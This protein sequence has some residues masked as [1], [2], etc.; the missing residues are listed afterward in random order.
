[1]IDRVMSPNSWSARDVGREAFPA[2]SGRR[3]IPFGFAI[4]LVLA[5]CGAR[6]SL[7]EGER[8]AAQDAGP[9]APLDAVTDTTW[10]DGTLPDVI[11]DA[12]VVTSCADLPPVLNEACAVPGH[13]CAYALGKQGPCDDV[14]TADRV[15]WRCEPSGWLEI[16]RCVE[17]GAC[18]PTPPADGDACDESVLGLDCYY[19]SDE[20]CERGSIAQCDG[21]R[22]WHVNACP[23]RDVPDGF[24][25]VSS[26]TEPDLTAVAH[27]EQQV[28]QPSLAVAGTQLLMAYY[29]SAGYLQDHGIHGHV[30]QTSAPVQTAPYYTTSTDLLGH[31]AVSNPRVTYAEGRFILSWG[32]N[33]GWPVHT[34]G[35]PGLYVRTVPLHDPPYSSPLVDEGGGAPTGL[36]MQPEGGRVAYRYS[37]VGTG[38]YAAAVV[39]LDSKGAPAPLTKVTL[40]D[41][42]VSTGFALPVPVAF[43]RIAPWEKGFAY[44]FPVT[45]SGDVWDD[46]GLMV[47]FH[48]SAKNP[49]EDPP[50]VRL[51]VGMPRRAGIA[52]LRD[53]SVVVAYAKVDTE[54]EGPPLFRL[55]R[56]RPTG[57]WDPL[58]DPPQPA[59]GED[60]GAGPVIVPFED[61][62]GV[63]WTSI[64]AESPGPVA[65]PRVMVRT[66]E[67][68]DHEE[69]WVG[70]AVQGMQPSDAIALAY[71]RVDRTLHVAW[72][73]SSTGLS[74]IERQRL[75]VRP[76]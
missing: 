72:T 8:W 21:M 46:S 18:P 6:T 75:I 31:D 62:F 38:K 52:T 51:T 36:V 35:V 39:V 44:L 27:A 2:A 54:P 40:A 9:D 34:N 70:D 73:R 12:V 20:G 1:M 37:V 53:G 49:T 47:Q 64:P 43:V 24:V 3:C 50:V 57:E 76:N 28:T 66:G 7:L 14:G 67:A 32:A 55:L 30:V 60:L 15:G 41:E 63:G 13:V 23:D 74:T 68:L 69:M 71:G 17:W 25:L 48:D 26:L 65:W 16:A 10:P 5:G 22:W 19:S 61:G 4:F 45:A 29:V 56:V 33:D 42:T 58:P 59:L 11:A